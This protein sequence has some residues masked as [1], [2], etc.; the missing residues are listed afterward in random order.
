MK[1]IILILIVDVVLLTVLF[2]SRA[3]CRYV[4]P[5]G[6]LLKFFHVLAPFR[7]V[8]AAACEDC[9]ACTQSCPAGVPIK[10]EVDRFGLI[11]DLNCMNCGDCVSSCPSGVLSLKPTRRAYMRPLAG[12][13]K[14]FPM[15]PW[16][17]ATLVAFVVAGLFA[18]RGR[19]F[20]DF[21]SAGFGLVVGGLVVATVSPSR[22]LPRPLARRTLR[23]R[24]P[25]GIVST[26]L[27]VGLVVQLLGVRSID[28]VDASLERG[29]FSRAV[30]ALEQ[31]RRSYDSLKGFVLY[32]DDFDDRVAD[33]VPA[34]K[35]RADQAAATGKWADAEVLC[36]AILLAKPSR[37]GTWGDLGTALFWQGDY[38]GAASCYTEVLRHDPDDLVALY[39]LA[40]T[41]IQL[42]QRVEAVDLVLQ[43]LS[44]DDVGTSQALIR[45]NPLFQLLRV[46]QRYVRVM[47]LY[48]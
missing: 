34:M 38:W 30:R 8:K 43:I 5:Y 4:C 9:G 15:R 1:G 26:F 36:R 24:V 6:L 10:L 11:H 17:D 14:R 44:I 28:I 41:R 33:R 37:F 45:E 29:E 12:G 32:L 22:L 42:G 16:V 35:A 20:G 40:L 3:F 13:T 39:H 7:I 23:Y 18:Y 31:G 27:V 2:G 25:L 19:E 21:L 47:S 48:D 46:D